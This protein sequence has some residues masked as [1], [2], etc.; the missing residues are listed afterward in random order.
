LYVF[1]FIFLHFI[2]R[3]T[4]WSGAVNQKLV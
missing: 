3:L 4:Q 2:Q 1:S